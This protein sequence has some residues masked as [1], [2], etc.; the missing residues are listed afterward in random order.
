MKI[1]YNSFTMING[2]SRNLIRLAQACPYPLYVVGG[3]TRDFLAGLKSERADTDI[4][5]PTL[6]EDFA[7]ACTAMHCPAI[8]QNIISS[9]NAFFQFFITFLL[10]T[11]PPNRKNLLN[12]FKLCYIIIYILSLRWAYVNRLKKIKAFKA[13]YF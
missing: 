12:G 10:F 9:I 11:K 6:A 7:A 5:A 8:R 1:R 2:L 13:F 3:R 4:C